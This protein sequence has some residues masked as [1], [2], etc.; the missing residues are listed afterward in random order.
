MGSMGTYLRRMASKLGKALLVAAA[1][2]LPQRGGAGA[3][4]K[5]A[6]RPDK[7]VRPR[8]SCSNACRDDCPDSISV[9][10]S[11]AL[12]A[13][14]PL[15]YELWWDNGVFPGQPAADFMWGPLPANLNE[16]CVRGSAGER[17]SGEGER[18]SMTMMMGEAEQGQRGERCMA[19]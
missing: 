15:W 3:P 16:V 13:Q 14:L 10:P 1:K 18:R 11:P 5:L 9:D 12:C 8:T 6:P 4:I 17:A 7:P 19:S 2:N